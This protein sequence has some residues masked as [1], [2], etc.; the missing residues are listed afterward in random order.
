MHITADQVGLAIGLFFCGL[1]A[2]Q[3]VVYLFT[4][5]RQFAW[6]R[7][8]AGLRIE[9]LST[10]LDTAIQRRR[11][12]PDSHASWRG[13]R[14]FVVRSVQRESSQAKS[15]I[16]VPEDRRPLPSFHP[17]QFLTVKVE[18]PGQAK[19]LQR[20]YSISDRPRP[21]QYRCTIKSIA[22]A[23]SGEANLGI[24]SRYINLSLQEGDVIDVKAP[25]GDFYL[26]LFDKRPA[27]L[28]AGGIGI[29][30]LMSMMEAVL[31]EGT[32][33]QLLLFYGVRNSREHVFRKRLTELAE[34]HEQLRVVTCYSRPLPED[35]VGS[36]F[37]LPGRISID[38]LKR[39]LPSSNY[40]FFLCGPS[41]FMDSLLADLQ[42]WDVP[43]SRIHLE[44][45]GSPPH[46]DDQPRLTGKRQDRGES[47]SPR[48]ERGV[49]PW[50][51]RLDHSGQTLAWNDDAASIL[52]CA[53]MQEVQLPFGCRQGNC[54]TCAA[55][56][57]SGTVHYEQKPD[58]ELAPDE[59]LPCQAQPTSDIV[60]DL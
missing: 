51:I 30:P 35:R 31:H 28:L 11:L 58:F 55:R 53:E 27:I 16:L 29:T 20:C 18:I 2:L 3:A 14:R 59:C 4:A 23:A 43:K 17:G 22:P 44:R 45:F 9:A 46:L 26:D 1:V 56:L 50:D 6:H 8:A 7:Q 5:T 38:L 37:D 33:R 49:E 57:V 25:G 39:L 34:R 40:E 10:E 47:D 36:D 15:I 12:A 41:G 24:V 32:S 21:D 13:Y 52:E 60:L 42:A 19:P 54:G 48:Q